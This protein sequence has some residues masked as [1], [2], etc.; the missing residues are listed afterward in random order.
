MPLTGNLFQRGYFCARVSIGLTVTN[1]SPSGRLTA[2]DHLSAVRM[3]TPS[4]TAWPPIWSSL[5]RW[6]LTSTSTPAARA[7]GARGRL[8]AFAFLNRDVRLEAL[9]EAL[10]APSRVYEL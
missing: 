1:M 4:M 10:H 5:R 6:S 2:S 3:T 7:S 8:L 9:L